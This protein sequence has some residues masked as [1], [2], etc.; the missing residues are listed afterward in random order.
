MAVF[1][2][3]QG[4]RFRKAVWTSA[5][6]NVIWGGQVN[7]LKH[8]SFTHRNC[9]RETPESQT[10][11]QSTTWDWR[12]ISQGELRLIWSEFQWKCHWQ[13]QQ[14]VLWSKVV[15]RALAVKIHIIMMYS[16]SVICH[17]PRRRYQVQIVICSSSSLIVVHLGFPHVTTHSGSGM[18]GSGHLNTANTH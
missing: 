10:S 14:Q 4:E 6:N 3:R 13:H 9:D 18:V 1:A 5:Q 8:L 2:L 7:V 15:P 16:S 17:F 12:H 11:Q